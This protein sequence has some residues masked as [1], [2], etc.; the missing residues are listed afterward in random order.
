MWTP[1]ISVLHLG[2]D[3]DH[4]N[5]SSR[6]RLTITVVHPHFFRKVML[7]VLI[8]I[9]EHSA[10]KGAASDDLR[11]QLAKQVDSSHIRSHDS[12]RRASQRRPLVQEPRSNL[13]WT[14]LNSRLRVQPSA[15]LSPSNSINTEGPGTIPWHVFKF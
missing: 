1:G 13:Y 2:S 15:D 5:S 9:P 8:S 6:E 12:C 14:I 3:F 10:R 11:S 7:V 4:D